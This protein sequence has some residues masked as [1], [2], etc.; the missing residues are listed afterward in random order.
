MELL[1]KIFGRAQP[2]ETR[3]SGAG[4]TAQII[5]ARAAYLAGTAGLGE[6]TAT[7]QGCVSLWEGAFALADVQG[8]DLLDRRRMALLARA[9]AMRGEAVFLIGDMGLHLATDWE[10]STRN[11]E[12]RAYRLSLPEAGGPTTRTA[13]AAEV[14]HLRI[15]SDTAAPWAGTS[16][17]RRAS[18]TAGLVQVLE[19]A[20][21]EI[22]AEAPLASQVL[23]VP[24]MPDDAREALGRDFRGRRG[25]VLLRESVNV[26][27]AGGPAPAQD[28]QPASMTPDLS[29]AL[30]G[31]S[32]EAAKGGILAAFGVLPALFD[33]AAQGPLVREAQRHLAG[34]MLQPIAE[35]IAEEARAKLGETVKIDVIRPLQAHDASGRA[36]ALQTLV[37]T[38]ARAKEAGLP[39]DAVAAAAKA[40]NM[41]GGDDLA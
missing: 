14:L 15:G 2:V 23:P 27:A 19:S 24:E 13:L 37:E 36:R 11:G 8:T 21:S 18:L 40:V 35:L 5:A 26:T 22:Y 28:W 29:R 3:S 32:L 6:L 7:V 1:T 34:W 9:L 30:I 4:Y 41:A 39:D 33:K 16:P 25:R 31:E 20:L 10:V 38:L 12:P 17:L